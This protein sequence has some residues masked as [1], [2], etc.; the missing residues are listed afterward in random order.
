MIRILIVLKNSQTY[1]NSMKYAH[2]FNKQLE[3][4]IFTKIE[5][6]VS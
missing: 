2:I 4:K 1:F 6:L 5:M 3:C